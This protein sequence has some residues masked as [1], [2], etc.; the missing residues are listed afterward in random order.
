VSST[1][2]VAPLPQWPRIPA[3]AS[4]AC[5]SRSATLFLAAL[6]SAL[7]SFYFWSYSFSI[8]LCSLLAFFSS[9]FLLAVAAMASFFVS[10]CSIL[11]MYSLDVKVLLCV[12]SSRGCCLFLFLAG[13]SSGRARNSLISP[14]FCVY[15]CAQNAGSIAMC[16]LL[17]SYLLSSAFGTST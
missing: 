16:C 3:A 2:T 4:F 9:F 17:T 12:K 13:M 8:F 7:S 1:A 5:R 6:A 15:S 11:V 10:N 14:P